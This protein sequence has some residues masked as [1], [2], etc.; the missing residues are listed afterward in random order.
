MGNLSPNSPLL[1]VLED[2]KKTLAELLILNEHYS[3]SKKNTTLG[4]PQ[5]QLDF[6]T[7]SRKFPTSDATRISHTPSAPMQFDQATSAEPLSSSDKPWSSA[8]PQDLSSDRSP[9]VQRVHTNQDRLLPSLT[10]SG[11]EYPTGSTTSLPSCCT[12]PA[13]PLMTGSRHQEQACGTQKTLPHYSHAAGAESSSAPEEGTPNYPPGGALYGTPTYSPEAFHCLCDSLSNIRSQAPRQSAHK[14][15]GVS[16]KQQPSQSTDDV[17]EDVETEGLYDASFSMWQPQQSRVQRQLF[18]LVEAPKHGHRAGQGQSKQSQQAPVDSHYLKKSGMDSKDLQPTL[19]YKKSSFDA[20]TISHMHKRQPPKVPLTL[21]KRRWHLCGMVWRKQ[22]H[23]R[24]EPRSMAE[25]YVQ[26]PGRH[27]LQLPDSTRA[28][29]AH[30]HAVRAQQ[31]AAVAAANGG[32]D[33]DKGATAACFV[34]HLIDSIDF[35]TASAPKALPSSKELGVIV[36]GAGMSLLASSSSWA[37]REAKLRRQHVRQLSMVASLAA[38]IAFGLSAAA[39]A[40][41]SNS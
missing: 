18:P 16:G 33:E 8:G 2:S 3:P 39:S 23:L 9:S 12:P 28:L 32:A 27:R 29:R 20:P 36:G 40:H 21:L 30:I 6:H 22:E 37:D 19:Q 17:P 1:Q 38:A 15:L 5:T 4:I 41:A 34:S 10:A 11:F 35:S 14:D 7:S 24:P 26:Q 31:Q 13:L 25:K